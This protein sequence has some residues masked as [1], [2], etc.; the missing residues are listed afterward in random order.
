MAADGELLPKVSVVVPVYRTEAYLKACVESILE[1]DYE[2][3]ELILVDDGS[4]DGCPALC[5]RYAEE[6]GQVRAVHQENQGPGTARNRGLREARGDFILFVD[7]D[8]LL[9]EP[10]TVW[11]LMD[12]AIRERADIVTG[13]YRRFRGDSFGPV[14]RHHLRGGDYAETVSFRLQGFLTEGQLLWDWGKLYRKAFLLE[15]QLWCEALFHMEDK[16]RNMMCC[17][18]EPR[19]AFVDDCVYLYRITEGSITR[20]QWE[21]T[22]ELKKDWIYV[23]EAFHRFLKERPQAERFR[24]LLAF[25]VFC[26]IFTIGRQPLQNGE[27]GRRESV[28]LLREYGKDALVR[29]ELLAL[30]KGKYLS[31]VPFFWRMLL[32]AGSLLFCLG[33]YR[34]I[35]WGIILL[36]GLG[37]ERKESRL[38]DG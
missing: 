23:A 16:L 18:C 21:M 31:G 29:Q 27:G 7:S 25:H 2:N 20:R 12:T 22:A 26:G 11:T 6:Y 30:A 38:R 10:D 32:Q 34:L 5:D 37:T 13:N 24:D 35:V 17:T 14:T 19:Y 15:N 8:D 36:R 28:E 4:P 9:N 1:Q 33:A 3:L